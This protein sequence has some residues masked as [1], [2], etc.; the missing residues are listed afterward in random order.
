ME[1]IPLL[2]FD[3]DRMALIEP[4]MHH[5]NINPP[6]RCVMPFYASVISKLK[7]EGV[8]QKIYELEP[9]SVLLSPIDV[10]KLNTGSGDISVVFPG[11]GAPLTAALFEEL[12]A[13]GCRKF[14]ACGSCGVLK[15]ELKR[16]AVVIPQAAVRDEGTSFHY[17]PPSRIIQMQP[18]VVRK[19]EII[20]N[21]HHVPYEVGITWTTDAFFRE[22]RNKIARRKAENCI[23][24]EMECAALLAVAKFRGVVF[25]QYLGAG[26]D[27]SGD[28][29][30]PRRVSDRLTFQEKLFWLSI[31][32]VQSL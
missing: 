25:G 26:D 4:S 29:W 19:L 23:T 18:N 1:D 20:L 9:A 8:M 21:K 32:A 27:V 11:L 16:G 12:I 15:P 30:D 10:Y 3:H 17:C 5:R 14:V 2:E 31:E 22:T 13:L 28:V 24:V 6:E 7:N